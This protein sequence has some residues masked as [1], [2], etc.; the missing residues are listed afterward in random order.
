MFQLLQIGGIG[1]RWVA[2]AGLLQQGK[3]QGQG[4]H[5]SD[6]WG[7]SSIAD[8]GAIIILALRSCDRAACC[9]AGL[10]AIATVAPPAKA[11]YGRAMTSPL[12]NVNNANRN[13]LRANNRARPMR[14]CD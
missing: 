9:A 14:V 6:A 7:H 8:C 1:A 5:A 3:Q 12:S 4:R 2:A 11:G 13:T 10:I